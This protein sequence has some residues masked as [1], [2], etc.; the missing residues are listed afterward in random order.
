MKRHPYRKVRERPRPRIKKF[1]C[2]LLLAVRKVL[3]EQRT[4]DLGS[5]RRFFYLQFLLRDI[6]LSTIRARDF[7]PLAFQPAILK[8]VSE[9]PGDEAVIVAKSPGMMS[10][11]DVPE[12]LHLSRTSPG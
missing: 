11:N 6:A 7:G 10:R 3:I 1:N 12:F 8:A 2:S 5:E 9:W 4:Q